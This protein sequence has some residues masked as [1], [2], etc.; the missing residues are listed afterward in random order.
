MNLRRLRVGRGPARPPPTTRRALARSAPRPARRGSPAALPVRHVERQPL[1]VG[2]VDHV[3]RDDRRP[4][5]LQHLAREEQIALEV[6][7][8]GH[9]QDG[10]G[11]RMPG[12]APA[13]AST[14]TCSS[15]VTASRLYSPGRSMSVAVLAANAHRAAAVLDRRA[16][17]VGGLGPQSGE[18]VEQRRLAGVRIAHQRN[19]SRRPRLARRVGR[20]TGSSAAATWRSER[21]RWS[22]RLDRHAAGQP[23]RQAHA[24]SS[25][26][27]ISGSPRLDQLHASPDA[28]AQRLE[29][30]GVVIGG[31]TSTTSATMPARQ[32]GEGH[33]S[34]WRRRAR[35]AGRG[36]FSTAS[37]GRRIEIEYH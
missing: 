17:K 18:L 21:A 28:N 31:R 13:S 12:A 30:H 35:S 16:G 3:E 9:E 25:T 11:R 24:G 37:A 7:R 22:E 10:V 4:T 8:I 34:S 29:S 14:A 15:G 20:S 36:E 32:I 1:L 2:R 27:T 26:R 23:R 19:R 6:G 5:E 33:R